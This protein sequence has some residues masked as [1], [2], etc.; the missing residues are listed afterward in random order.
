VTYRVHWREDASDELAS[1]WIRGDAAER[2]NVTFATDAID[3]SLTAN[4][5]ECGESRSAGR[6]I[7]FHDP[8][9]IVFQVFEPQRTVYVL[10]VWRPS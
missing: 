5:N 9:A 8:L 4:P 2:R 6:R 3:K 10:Q 7:F 1:I